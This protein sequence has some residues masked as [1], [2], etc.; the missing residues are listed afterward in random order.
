MVGS[1]KS[2]PKS[3]EF[4]SAARFD[5]RRADDIEGR[6]YRSAAKN[7]AKRLYIKKAIEQLESESDR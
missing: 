7:M 5:R 4:S 3:M 2:Y 1:A 6:K